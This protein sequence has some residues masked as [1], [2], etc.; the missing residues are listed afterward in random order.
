MTPVARL[1]ADW[2]FKQLAAD[3][4]SHRHPQ[5]PWL[6]AKG[7]NDWGVPAALTDAAL[8][9]V[10]ERLTAWLAERTAGTG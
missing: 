1:H 5:T 3:A 2:R 9:A 6:I 8:E 7:S 10:N 4:I